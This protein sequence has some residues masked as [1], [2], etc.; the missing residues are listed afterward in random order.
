MVSYLS[1]QSELENHGKVDEIL[2]RI[3]SRSLNAWKLVQYLTQANDDFG[4]TVAFLLEILD[5]TYE[6][7]MRYPDTRIAARLPVLAFR[8]AFFHDLMI[9]S[10]TPDLCHRGA[11]WY[12]RT[13]WRFVW[14]SLG[15]RD[16]YKNAITNHLY[17]GNN[18]QICNAY[19]GGV[20]STFFKKSF[21]E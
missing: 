15:A 2:M 8:A 9:E 6:Y 20:F 12:V 19:Q 7:E 21:S 10:W 17:N 11:E 1:S 13:R 5:Y 14:P 18:E 4:W 16:I 3:T